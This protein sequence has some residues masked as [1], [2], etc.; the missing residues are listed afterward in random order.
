[1]GHQRGQKRSHR[2][3][4]DLTGEHPFGDAGQLILAI[5]FAVVWITDTFFFEYTTFL[6]QYLPDIAGILAGAILLIF[7]AY[8][9]RKA[10]SIVF[11]QERE[12]PCVIRKSIFNIIR[13]PIYVSE[14]LF[15]LGLLALSISLAA[16]A[17]LIVTVW[18]LHFISRY[19]ERLL[20]ERFGKDYEQYMW[21]VPMWIPRFRNR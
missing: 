7:S 9:A 21:E 4:D 20:L 10:L 11:G 3:R 14:I 8:V 19:E 16:A 13:H 2:D 6:N 17:V 15:Y 1:M 18:F 12:N 5:I